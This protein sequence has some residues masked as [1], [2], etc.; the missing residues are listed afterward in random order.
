MSKY[1]IRGGHN[2]ACPGA[3]AIIDE[4]TEDRKVKDAVIKYLKLAG[5]GTI[6]VTPGNCNENTDL[7][8][9]TNTAN[10]AHADLFIP[11]H[12]NKAYNSYAGAIGTEVWLNP[13]NAT[14][15]AV[16]NRILH[17]L[18]ALG[19]KNRGIK[20]GINGEH[21]HDIR[22]SNMPAILVEVCFCE[23]VADVKIYR[24]VGIDKIGKV[25][26]EGI[27]GHTIGV[28]TVATVAKPVIAIPVVKPNIYMTANIQSTGLT[29]TSGFNTCK[30]GTIGKALRLEAF[31]MHIDDVD[32]TYSSHIQSIGDTPFI[33]ESQILGTIGLSLRL[34]GFTINATKIP[35]GYKFQYRANIENLG[36]TSWQENNTFCGTTGKSLRIEEI[37]VQIIKA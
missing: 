36:L 30:I 6:D 15:V 20:D 5:V 29:S 7:D 13:K 1:A 10:N 19:F 25:I 34:E 11:I 32:F 23:S 14:A 31:S 2:F 26:A 22:T 12:F 21:L 28:A 16:G 37:E 8:Y 24:A 17:N 18:S 35:S 33:G 3:S 27:L 9:G 4:T